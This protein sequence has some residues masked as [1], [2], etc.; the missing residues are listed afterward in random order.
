MM[1]FKLFHPHKIMAQL[2]LR[3]LLGADK[4]TSITISKPSFIMGRDSACDHQIV[5]SRVSRQHCEITFENEQVFVRD[6]G[7][8]NGVQLNCLPITGVRE[9]KNGDTI[10]LGTTTAFLV[11][12]QSSSVFKNPSVQP[13]NQPTQPVS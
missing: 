1:D 7:S 12:I 13:I 9:A 2:S 11:E 10:S 5:S 6:L 8:R 3:V 4:G